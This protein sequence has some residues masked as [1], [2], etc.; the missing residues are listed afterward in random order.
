MSD[1]ARTTGRG[2]LVIT[3]AKVWF[4]IT[5]AIVSLGLPTIFDLTQENGEIAFGVYGVVINHVSIFNMVMISGTLQAVSKLVSEV[6]QRAGA[7]LR[8]AIRVQLLIGLPIAAAYV[9]LSAPMAGLLND[10]QL[11]P[12]LRLSGLIVLMYSFYAIFVGYFNGR[13]L[14]TYQA[15][16]DIGFA[17]VKTVLVLGAVLLGMGV[18]GA[19]GGFVSTA[20]LITV[21][22]GAWAWKTDRRAESA[23]DDSI[24]SRDLAKRLV[25][26]MLAVMA[27]TLL[28]NCIIRADLFIVKSM[29]GAADSAAGAVDAANE[30][31]NRLAGVYTGMVN[32]ARLPYQAV[33]AITFVAFPLIS[34]TT[35]EG[36]REAARTYIRQT[37]RYSLLLVAGMV[38]VLIA[39]RET[40]VAALY[41]SVYAHGSAALLW[42]GL[43]MMAFALMFVSTTVLI[44]A[45]R[46]VASLGVAGFT[47][48]AAVG[49]NLGFLHG[50]QPG[51]SM[52]ERAGLATAIATGAGALAALAVLYRQYRAVL[53]PATLLRVVVAG[54]IIVIVGQLTPLTDLMDGMS[55]SLRLLVV[56]GKMAILAVLF[57]ALL[58]MLREFG[59]ADRARL[60]SVLS[61]KRGSVTEDED[62]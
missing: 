33:I 12:Y 43:A 31:S 28:L 13:K 58:Y 17:T 60:A 22:A 18:M 14:F 4:M 8:Q 30:L 40:L 44:G 48:A 35:F 34:Q 1:V 27:Y 56:G 7:V 9:L 16:L 49:L 52:L 59:A 15:S 24:G 10:G 42:L 47:L 50:L 29:S 20:V 21:L 3:S 62:V 57:Y 39:E 5:G 61:R 37:L 26:Y 45:G 46:P 25:G 19:I 51:W 11:T 36:D 53:P 6:P 38:V 2:F 54:F 55:R 41:P 23:S 32:V